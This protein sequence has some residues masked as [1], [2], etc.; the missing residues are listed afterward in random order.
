MFGLENSLTDKEK[1]GRAEGERTEYLF[2]RKDNMKG[3]AKAAKVI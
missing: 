1:A 2:I 3:T